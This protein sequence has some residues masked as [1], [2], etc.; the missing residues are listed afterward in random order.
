LTSN[1]VGQP[2]RLLR[3][4]Y[5]RLRDAVAAPDG[6][7]WVLTDNTF[8]GQPAPADDRLVAFAL[9]DLR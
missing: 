4:R 6:R 2:Q 7:L 5:G 3:G 1:G 8:R 9:S